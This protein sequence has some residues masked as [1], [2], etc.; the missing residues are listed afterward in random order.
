MFASSDALDGFLNMWMGQKLV[1]HHVFF[2]PKYV[3]GSFKYVDGSKKWFNMTKLGGIEPSTYLKTTHDMNQ[4][5][6]THIWNHILNIHE[7]HP[8]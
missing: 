1:L 2:G 7:N 5:H 4:P 8:F 6:I 3:D